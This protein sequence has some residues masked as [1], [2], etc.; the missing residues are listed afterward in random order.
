MSTNFPTTPLAPTAV[1]PPADERTFFERVRD[2]VEDALL[3]VGGLT[4]LTIQ[5]LQ[6][7]FRG[8]IERAD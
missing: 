6:Q 7:T 4:E 5:T 2:H 8:K 3:Y 1:L